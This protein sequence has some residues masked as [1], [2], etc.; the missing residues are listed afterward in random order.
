[1]LSFAAL[2]TSFLLYST[3]IHIQYNRDGKGWIDSA[4]FA[5]LTP[6][7]VWMWRYNQVPSSIKT[8]GGVAER[9]RL[10]HRGRGHPSLP[11]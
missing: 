6:L 2:L 4:S 3:R 10:P 7:R 5:T 9:Q 8:E 11:L 1:M